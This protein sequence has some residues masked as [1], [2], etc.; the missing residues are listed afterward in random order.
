MISFYSKNTFAAKALIETFEQYQI[1]IALFDDF[2]KML[3]QPADLY[4][5]DDLTSD[6]YEKTKEKTEPCFYLQPV[7]N[8][9]DNENII[10]KP[11]KPLYLISQI[12][13]ILVCNMK[14]DVLRIKDYVLNSKTNT[15]TSGDSTILLT[16][17]ETQVLF[18]LSQN[19]NG[20]SKDDLLS[21]I[22]GYGIEIT[23][24]TLETHIYK[25]RNKLEQTNIEIL[26]SGDKYTIA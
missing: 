14:G 19:E 11:F 10:I 15:L 3:L 16:S 18:F 12:Y 5:F 13:P 25:L 26:L 21:M 22:W 7:A 4:L 1:D 24:H 2:E 6:Q 17:K 8:H 20:L 23:T 9:N